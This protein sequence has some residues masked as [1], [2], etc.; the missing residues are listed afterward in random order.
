MND[1]ALRY[2]LLAVVG[3]LWATVIS[4]SVARG[5]WLPTI[6]IVAMTASWLPVRQLV[7]LNRRRR[8]RRTDWPQGDSAW[9]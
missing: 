6:V 2:A 7:Q 5:E 3:V 8:G 1:D 4:F 9:Y